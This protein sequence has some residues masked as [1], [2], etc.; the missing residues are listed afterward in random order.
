MS[1]DFEYIESFIRDIADFPIPGIVFKDITPVLQNGRAFDLTIKALAK[2]SGE[3][4]LVAG[5]EARGFIFGAALAQYLGKG[6]IPIRK[7]GK[8]PHESYIEAYN[9]EYGAN[10]LEIHTDAV[11]PGQRVLIVDDILATGGTL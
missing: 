9:L 8:L 11:K 6:F 4:D 2:L 3:Y 7:P 10:S 5:V 1:K